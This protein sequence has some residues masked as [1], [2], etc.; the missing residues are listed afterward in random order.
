MNKL[1]NVSLSYSSLCGMKLYFWSSKSNT[2]C[3]AI[4]NNTLIF[5][6]ELKS[7]LNKHYLKVD[8]D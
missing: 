7:L 4:G 1:G 6:R 3:S 5:F 2:I 8:M